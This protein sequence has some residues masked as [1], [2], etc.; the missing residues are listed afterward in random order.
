MYWYATQRA[1]D[2]RDLQETYAA[3]AAP[4]PE[5]L[6]RATDILRHPLFDRPPARRWSDGRVTLLGDAAHPMLPFIG[7]GACQAIEDAVALG[8]AVSE[9]GADP[10]ALRAYERARRKRAAMLVK[11]SRTAGRIAHARSAWKRAL[12]DALVRHTPD[13]ARYRQLDAAIGV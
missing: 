9:H 6:R 8:A 12:R 1:G 13:G 2:A 4:V 3:W 11:R 5:I 7:Q 10:D